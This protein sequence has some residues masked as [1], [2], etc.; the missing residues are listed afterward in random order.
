MLDL[1]RQRSQ[2]W[3]IKLAFG[4]IILVFVFWG[5]GSYTDTGPGTAATVNGKP[6]LMQDFMRELHA[7]EEQFRSM[8]PDVSSEELR[9]LRLP[10]QVLSRLVTRAL[11]EQEAKRL[12]VTVTPVEYAAYVRRQPVFQKDGV[13]DQQVYELFVANQGKGIADF[14]QGFMREMLMEKM[15]NY[16]TASV[17]VTPEEARKRLGFE[18]ERRVI[19]YVLFPIDDYREGITVTDDAIKAFY[20]GN[21]AQFAQ[22][23]TIAI[24]YLDVTP[25]AIAHTMDVSGEEIEKAYAAGPL[26]YN[27]RQ[28]HLPVPEGTDEAGVAALKAELEA[29]A[30]TLRT[31]AGVDEAAF[32][33][34]TKAL[35][36]KHPDARMGESG[37]MEARR[38]PAELLGALAGLNKGEVAPVVTMEGVLV[39]AQLVATDPDWSLSEDEIK[40]ALRKELGEEKAA[41]AFRDVQAQ[42]EDLVALGRPVAEIAKELHL[43]VKTTNPAPRDE[44][45]QVLNLRKPGQV[46]LFE[47]AKGTLVNGILET[48]DGFVV[49]EIA[50]SQL[51]GVKPLEE[52]EGLIRDVLVQREAEKKA[53]EAARGAA[54][55][56]AKS[57]SGGVPDAYKDKIV[58]SEPFNRQGNIP[59]LGF[60]KSLCDTVF[61]APLDAWL[62]EPFATP[63]GAVIAM[64]A[65]TIPL[66]DEEWAK[67]E[68]RAMDLILQSKKGQVMNAFLADLHKQADVKIPNTGIFE[69]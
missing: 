67:I 46:S 19:S 9:L 6:I 51:A 28:V 8:A 17:A 2:S 36:E 44:L 49:A 31:G 61:S 57:G 35:A 4:I 11:V 22:P 43:E 41:L 14:E 37:M 29:V 33:E 27:T 34:A 38:M 65:E 69:Q 23:A 59:G 45:V 64:P 26:R 55:E 58:T 1:I 16:I 50:D 21:Q 68:G 25:E 53:E 10:E 40:T 48:R 24:S 54:A 15:Q 52:V 56:F 47:G 7:E 63:A 3:L 30:E 12:G 5:V 42:A 32:N 20:D 13:F 39:L 62:A 66:S 18:M 60:A